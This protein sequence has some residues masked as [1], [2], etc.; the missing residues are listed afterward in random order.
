M[1]TSFKLNMRPLKKVLLVLPAL[2]LVF[3]CIG[4]KTSKES[5]TLI[6]LDKNFQFVSQVDGKFFCRGTIVFSSIDENGLWQ[7]HQNNATQQNEIQ[8]TAKMVNDSLEIYTAEPWKETWKVTSV[9]NGICRGTVS[10]DY[11]L[12]QNSVITFELREEGIP[13]DKTYQFTSHINGEVFCNGTFHFYDKDE[14]GLWHGSQKNETRK[15]E[16]VVTAKMVNDS[17][18][19]Y[20]SEQWNETWKVTSMENGIST[21]SVSANYSLAQNN[22]ITFELC[23]IVNEN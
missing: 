5:Q 19:I 3:S 16:I 21:G 10:A 7:G 4:Q 6:Q 14:N 20:T 23:E 13:L 12:A 8:V 9:K 1:M 2:F 17:L 18:E 11:R 15:T 22:N